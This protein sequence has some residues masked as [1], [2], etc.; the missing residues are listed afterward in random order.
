MATA[1]AP[2]A[3]KH[4]ARWIV[5]SKTDLAWFTLGGVAASYAF[6]ALWRFSHIPLLLLVA[7]WGIVFDET[8]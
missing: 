2:L 3:L 8:H 5:S 1:A 4:P 7:V 6:W